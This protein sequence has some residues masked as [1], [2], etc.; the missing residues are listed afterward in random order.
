M[1]T[2]ETIQ[3]LREHLKPL[4]IQGK[5]IGFVPTMGFLHQGHISLIE[6]SISEN[7]VT[8]VSIFVNPA[9]FQPNMDLDRYPR[10]LARDQAMLQNAGVNFLFYP[11]VK[12]I[13]PED[14]QTWVEVYKLTDLLDGA[15]RAGYFKGI[16]TIVLKLFNIVQADRTYFGQKDIQQACVIQK[17]IKDLHLEIDLK[18]M[19][20]IREND[21][22]AMSSRNAYLND[23]DRKIA[24]LL[25]KALNEAKKHFEQGEKRANILTKIVRS[26]LMQE[27]SFIIDY[28]DIVDE[29]TMQRVEQINDKSYLALA[30]DLHG[31]RL[32]DNIE[33]H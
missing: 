1:L 14:Y 25:Y 20:I 10:N 7:A 30:V 19:P 13:Y 24:P 15:S 12:E 22:L 3:E 17:M 23:N 5:S 8:V 31:T 4:K 28:I 21:G 2:L 9:Q 32:I 18:I 11:E 33:L 26:I 16:C 29:Q 27:K 6:K